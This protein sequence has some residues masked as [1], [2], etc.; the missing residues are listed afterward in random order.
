MPKN[1]REG[2]T[3]LLP[4]QRELLGITMMKVTQVQAGDQ[5][6][7]RVEG[8]LAGPWVEELERSWSEAAAAR[9]AARV[10]VELAGVSFVDEDGKRLLAKMYRAGTPLDAAGC[11]TRAIVEELEGRPQK[12]RQRL[13]HREVV[14]L[15]AA[16]L[17][18]FSARPTAAQRQPAP[19]QPAAPAT[20]KLTLHDAV[21]MALRQNPQVQIGDIDLAESE[22]NVNISRSALLPQASLSVDDRAVRSNIEA[23]FGRPFPNFPEHIGPFQVFDAATVFS[24]P[25]LDLTLWQQWRAA[26]FQERASGDD[27]MSVREQVTLLVVSQ[28]LASLRAT[29]NVR[30]AQARVQLAQTLY[31]QASDLQTRGVGTGLD[32]LRANVELQNEQQNLIQA[33]TAEKT[34]LYG[35]ARLLNVNPSTQLVLTDQLSFY[36]TPP[37]NA[38][39]SIAQAMANRPEMKSIDESQLGLR[40]EI[41]AASE[42]RLPTLSFEG[43]YVQEGISAATVIPTYSYEAHVQMPLFTGGR[44]RA[45]QAKARLALDR[46]AQ[47]KQD[48]TNEIVLQVKT[49][50]AQLDSARHEVT[51]AN[52]GVALAQQEVQQARDR[53]QAGVADNIEVV[54]AQDALARANDNQIGA[55]FRYN[56]A[57][58]DLARATGQMQDLYAK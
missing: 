8:R 56:T 9:G 35:L 7:I 25:I 36:R 6:V 49:A 54:T 17:I 12:R 53:F 29:A 51:V 5:L 13:G 45:Q 44:I 34:S 52:L 15:L 37:F 24:V 30:A 38:Q 14:C 50:A 43:Q 41:H 16:L 28:Y 10:Q 55:L 2:E 40:A 42:Q 20:L 3:Q 22:Q 26:R 19:A 48:L 57:R 47:R 4:S 46:L 21:T 33:Q 23:N 58:A 39:E 18:C 31:Q 1:W 27:S 32:T 11:L